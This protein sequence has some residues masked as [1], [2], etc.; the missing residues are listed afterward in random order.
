MKTRLLAAPASRRAFLQSSALAAGSLLFTRATARAADLAKPANGRLQLALIGV[1]GRGK[2]ALTALQ[3]EQIVAFCD[4]DHVRGREQVAADRISSGALARFPEARWFHDYRVMFEQMADQIDAAV[5]SV[6]DF[7]HYAIGLTALRYGKHLYMEKPL[8]RCITE[9]RALRAAA[10][11]AGVVTQMGNQGRAAEGIRLAR[12][13]VQ[14]GLIGRVHTVHAWN[15]T[16]SSSYSLGLGPNP[17]ATDETPPPS[18]RYDLWQGVAPERPYRKVRSHGSW[19]G[20]VDYGTGRLGDWACHQLDAAVYAL[21]L[22]APLSVE[23]ATTELPP[24]T[25]PASATLEY[26]FAARG[27]NPPVRVRW[28]DGGILPPQPVP[29]FKFNVAGGSIF[30]GD[31]GVMA[32]GPHSS[33][34]RL[35]PDA[36]M[37][38]LRGSLPPKSIPRI[39]GGPHVEWVNAIRAGARCGSDFQ[40]AAPLAEIALLGVA[41]IRAQARLDWDA[42]A[43]RVTNSP[44][45]QRFIGP[46]YD[47]RPGWGA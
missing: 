32:V 19:R 34:A 23:P 42:T 37:A 44:A 30:Y 38:E 46:G 17:D 39:V 2:A 22:G 12:E 5:V 15:N 41:A 8:C 13:W 45:A 33:T 35:L 14:A 9:V 21:D 36:R 43:G 11:S 31:K 3:G 40:N 26:A 18:L 1:G 25:F 16:V 27:K 4:V 47:Y 28:F 20:Y 6:P 24:G 7:M 29:G 10:A